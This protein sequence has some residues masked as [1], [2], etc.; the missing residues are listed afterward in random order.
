MSD[1]ISAL[2][3]GRDGQEL[4]SG[5]ETDLEKFISSVAEGNTALRAMAHDESLLRCSKSEVMRAAETLEFISR[6]GMPKG[7]LATL[8]SGNFFKASV[9][10]F[11]L[12]H[13]KE[14]KTNS[15]DFPLVFNGSSKAMTELI[16][17]YVRQGRTFEL[18]GR[19]EL[20]LSYAADPNL[21]SW[22][23][24]SRLDPKQLP[25]AVYS[26]QPVFRNFRSGELSI[27]RTR[28]FVVPDIHIVADQDSASDEYIHGVELA[29][30][31]TRF[32]FGEDFV[33]VLDSVVGSANDTEEFYARVGKATA[34]ITVVRRLAQRP[35]YYAQKTGIM[36]WSGYDNVMLYNLQ[37]DEV[38]PVRFDIRVD[39]GGHPTVIHACV[40]MGL[41]RMLPILLGRGIAGI[42]EKTFPVELSANQVTVFPL[43]PGNMP[44]ARAVED[45]LND[46]GV[47]TRIDMEFNSQIGAR[48][49]K[50]RRLWEAK[51]VVVGDREMDSLPLIEDVSRS[52][53]PTT[54]DSF[55]GLHG[56]RI[57]RCAPS[58]LPHHR[59]LPFLSEN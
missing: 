11:N 14:L 32:W 13:L 2:V 19:D 26:P 22:L 43:T 1:V 28:Q 39:G 27:Q 4:W 38:N 24:G 12:P 30:E 42:S 34:G 36:L 23:Q 56:D 8:P 55:I 35:K 15:I 17:P 5:A 16:D 7:F 50:L 37:L 51:Y 49:T 33:H 45:E 41:S 52:V 40:A 25:Y 20:M 21:F 18:G 53:K 54:I 44:R 57:R 9:D 48:V 46:A 3:L 29:V 31:S 59:P 10:A 6:K 47:R 58:F